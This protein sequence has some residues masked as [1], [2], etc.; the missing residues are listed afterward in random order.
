MTKIVVKKISFSTYVKFAALF[1]VSIG[2][3]MAIMAVFMFIVF[4]SDTPKEELLTT[5]PPLFAFLLAPIITAL[6]LA[7][8]G[9]ITYPFYLLTCKIFKTFTLEVEL[10]P[11]EY[12]PQPISTTDVP[13][14]TPVNNTDTN[15][16]VE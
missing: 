7:M 9:V 14:G 13:Y 3:F 15:Q 6:P 8:W 1:G 5:L 2:M 10:P 4:L 16:G 11:M 12:Q